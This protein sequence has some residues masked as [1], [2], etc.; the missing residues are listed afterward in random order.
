MRRAGMNKGLDGAEVMKWRPRGHSNEAA[1]ELA[2]R[3]APRAILY[4][5]RRARKEVITQARESTESLRG[6]L[7]RWAETA[8]LSL[9][10][11]V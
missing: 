7:R 6:I 9:A 2:T 1:P 10:K 5:F 4:S 11:Y 8:G 3:K